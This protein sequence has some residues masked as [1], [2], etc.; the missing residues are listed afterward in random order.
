MPDP[1][2]VP[3][4]STPGPGVPRL[5]VAGRTA[6][7]LPP[8]DAP[9]TLARVDLERRLAEGTQRRLA[10]VIAGAGFGKST[11]AAHVAAGTRAA[12]YTLDAADRHLGALAAGIVAALRIRLPDLPA[13]LTLPVEGSV[14]AVDDAEALERAQAAAALVTDALQDHLAGDLVVVLDDLQAIE[15]AP[16]AWRFVE[17]LVRLAPPELHLLVTSR[18]DLPFGIERL[19]GQG[20]VVDLSGPVLSFTVE[21]I[22]AIV[23]SVLVDE[24]LD[25]AARSDVAA[26]IHAATGGWP[27]AVRLALEA[28][29]G[30]PP[31]RRAAA[32]ERL[33]HP[34]GPLFAY[35]AEEVVS[36]ATPAARD[37]IARAVHFDR[38][39]AGLCEAIGAPD[40]SR[41]LAAMG[42]RAFL[43]QTHPDGE[44]WYALHGLVREYAL[45]RLPLTPAEIRDVQA[46]AA[47]W[48]ERQGLLE[49]ALDARL[50]ADDPAALARFLT[51]HG[52]TLVI[53][54]ATRKVIEATALVPPDVRTARM[55]RA[56]GEAYL[57]RGAWRDA[58]AAF[59]R[60]ADK[61]GHL[62]AATA[63]RM[64]LV[65]GLRGAYDEALAI[66]RQAV[67]DGSQPADEALLDAWI[68]SA[69][70]HRGDVADSRAA[71]ERALRRAAEVGDARALAAAH[72]ARGMSHELDH[73]PML[74]AAEFEAALDAAE[75][76]GDTIQVIR[77][78]NSMGALDLEAGRFEAAL[79]VLDVA[80]RTADTVGFAAFH[81]RALVNRGRAKQG[82]GR[83]EEA[84]ADFAAARDIYERLGSP[85]VAYALTR[86]GSLHVL[87][88]D[89]FL[90]RGAFERAVRAAADAGDHHALA[91]AC[92]GLATAVALDDPD[93]ARRL[94]ARALELG[95]GIDPVDLH[96]GAARVA[97]SLDDRAD[98][99]MHAASAVRIAG[100]RRDEPGVAAGLE[101]Q[102]L[103]TD[104]RAEA[105]RLVD[106]ATA[107]WERVPAP[108]GIARNRLV[109][110]EVVDG[111][112]GRAAAVDA[113]ARFRALGARGRATEAAARVDDFDRAARPPLVI[114]SLGRFRVIR[115]GEVVPSTAWQSKKARD[116][117]KILV[118]RRGRPTTRETFF[119]LLWP[120]EDPE[121]L[122]NRLSVALATVRSVL[123]P[124]RRYPAE[125]FLA[126]DKSSVSL[127]LEHVDLDI[128]RF[129]DGAAAAARDVRSGD[130][131]EARRSLEAAEALYG[132]DFLEEDPYED[133]AVATREEA[134]A[135]YIGIARTLAASA[136]EAGDADLATR[137]Y[138]RILERDPYDEGAHLGLVAALRAAGR[139]GE[140][141]RRYGFYA[142][143]MEEIA[144]EAA[145]FPDGP[146]I[147]VGGGASV[148]VRR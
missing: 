141:R 2:V 25:P 98:A 8:A 6:K 3:D 45:N 1:T 56:C 146:G 23:A 77:I 111:P 31:D 107:I 57:V 40:A 133:W 79:A 104:D 125:Y 118:A 102:A 83:F 15:D 95:E 88:G 148:A 65:H 61:R 14:D 106:A 72:T 48:F 41:I 32:L 134:Q 59:D 49:A 16:A 86:E 136:A 80:V 90:A 19:R 91:P 17:A 124:E 108:F 55:E 20:Q 105:R 60:A 116:L 5:G 67:V 74:A 33:Q 113:E 78:R 110:A 144:V 126:A 121:P 35:L 22:D 147:P 39:D 53:G 21:E 128:A 73:E 130:V 24:P 12:W 66:Y 34:E 139:H 75:R 122:G 96:I 62:D 46:R 131:T 101:L 26:R 58:Y 47:D 42:R 71:A 70:Y 43:I 142:A 120:D 92:M 37:L 10:V 30:V 84:L 97:I 69:H 109:F 132:G 82:V 112:E 11:L 38:F 76:A 54:G 115:D 63:W 13:D 27:A 28:Y 129:L 89:S 9:G 94:V 127:D 29:R 114:G 44:G 87:R 7:L 119:E 145:P 137:Y 51:D 93:E 50:L 4:P 68:A 140:A 36:R 143:K 135:T 99:A 117:L 64:G 85:S 18:T 138:L 123:D 103:T 81:A 100:A 52:P